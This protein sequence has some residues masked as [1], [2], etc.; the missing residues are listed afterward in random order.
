MITIATITSAAARNQNSYSATSFSEMTM[1]SAE[2]MKSVRIAPATIFS[3]ASPPWTAAVSSVSSWWPA[4]L[5]QIF[6]APSK[7][8]YVPPSMS[9]GVSAHGAS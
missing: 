3:S 8:R 9:R 6:S 4:R 5:P 7:Q 2:R 1:I